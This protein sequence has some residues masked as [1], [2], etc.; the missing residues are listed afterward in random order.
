MFRVFFL[1]VCSVFNRTTAPFY[2]LSLG[3]KWLGLEVKSIKCLLPRRC[4]EP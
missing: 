2:L 3:V 1:S 4:L